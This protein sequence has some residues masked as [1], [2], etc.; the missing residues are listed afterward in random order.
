MPRVFRFIF[1]PCL[2]VCV[3]A[4]AEFPKPYN[5]GTNPAVPELTPE[6]ARQALR[7]PEGFAL[8]RLSFALEKTTLMLSGR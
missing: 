4:A 5:S 6:A 8:E 7:L 3:A 2:A 1:A